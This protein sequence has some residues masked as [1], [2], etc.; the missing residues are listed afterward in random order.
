MFLTATVT[1]SVPADV[2]D[3]DPTLVERLTKGIEITLNTG[4]EQQR[5][6]DTCIISRGENS[7]QYLPLTQWMYAHLRRH[8][9]Y[10]FR[11]QNI[12]GTLLHLDY[13]HR[14]AYV[15]NQ[16]L[17]QQ[18]EAQIN[19]GRVWSK[20]REWGHVEGNHGH[21]DV[22]S[23]KYGFVVPVLFSEIPGSGEEPEFKD[24]REYREYQERRRVV[25]TKAIEISKEFRDL[26]K[27]PAL[28]QALYL[29]DPSA[30]QS[31]LGSF[32][33]GQYPP[34]VNVTTRGIPPDSKFRRLPGGLPR[35]C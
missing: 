28:V 29:M 32:P 2:I 14:I 15:I 13:T 12:P 1:P 7:S 20:K 26:R 10:E 18:P 17:I 31:Y 22:D 11:Q 27:Y 21:A 25:P 24:L 35:F 30:Y 16:P 23:S 5:A 9:G 33:A 3:A 19:D 8:T 4:R 6:L 34:D